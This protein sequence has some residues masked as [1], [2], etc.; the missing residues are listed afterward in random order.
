MGVST[1]A[2]IMVLQFPTFTALGK[3]IGTSKSI[4]RDTYY[5]R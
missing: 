2:R 5:V 4:E 3:R 1:V